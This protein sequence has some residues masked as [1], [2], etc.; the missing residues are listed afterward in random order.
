M[1]SREFTRQLILKTVANGARSIEDIAL[2]CGGMFPLELRDVLD[3]L[4]ATGSLRGAGDGY[5]L[6]SPPGNDR[7]SV[8]HPPVALRHPDLPLPHP[9]DHDWRFDPPTV[10][11]LVETVCASTPPGGHALLLGAPTVFASLIE[12]PAAPAATLVDQNQH[13]L[14]ALDQG[15]DGQFRTYYHNLLAG[16]EPAISSSADVAL[17]DPPWYPEHYR[18]FLLQ[19]S[20]AT[21]IGGRILVSLLPVT[22]RPSAIDDR[23]QLLLEAHRFGL[24]LR[25]LTPDRLMYESPPFELAS[26][27]AGGIELLRPWRRGDL[28]EFWKVDEPVP[29]AAGVLPDRFA[30]VECWFDM[31]INRQT[32]KLRG[33]FIDGT[34]TPQLLHIEDRDVL[35]TVSRRYPGRAAVDLWLWDNRVFGVKGRAAFR[36]ALLGLGGLPPPDYPPVRPEHVA[37]ALDLIHTIPGLIDTT[38][39]SVNGSEDRG[40]TGRGG[41]NAA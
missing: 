32:I 21:R 12:H 24:Q 1:D 15:P 4:V 22:T 23:G 35:P 27:A 39:E 38:D 30:G 17:C 26:L 40:D 31:H 33:P 36:A 8:I 41:G 34:E 37:R 11:L 28:A 6:S 9:L 18:A 29:T 2:G 14:R 3:G 19:A 7:F 16:S 25:S 13:L 5:V 20:L 10:A